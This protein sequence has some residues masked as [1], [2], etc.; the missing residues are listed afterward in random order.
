MKDQP[1]PVDGLIES[2]LPPT[3]VELERL[4]GPSFRENSRRTTHWSPATLAERL[5][6]MTIAIHQRPG[7]P[8][9]LLR[10]ASGASLKRH[11]AETG[12]GYYSLR[13]ALPA[14]AVSLL[15]S[16]KLGELKFVHLKALD[17]A[18]DSRSFKTPGHQSA[19]FPILETEEDREV[20]ERGPY[21]Y[22][23]ACAVTSA[24][25]AIPCAFE[26]VPSAHW[27]P[28]TW[29]ARAELL[30]P[31]LRRDDEDS[32]AYLR[33]VVDDYRHQLAALA[34]RPESFP[35]PQT[36]ADLTASVYTG[37]RLGE[38]AAGA[39]GYLTQVASAGGWLVA[40]PNQLGGLAQSSLGHSL[41][42]LL[43]IKDF[44]SMTI[45]DLCTRGAGAGGLEDVAWRFESEG[46]SFTGP[47]LHQLL[48]TQPGE[49]PWRNVTDFAPSE[50]GVRWFIARGAAHYKSTPVPAALLALRDTKGR[51]LGYSV[52]VCLDP[53]DRTG[54]LRE[55]L[56]IAHADT[57]RLHG[58]AGPIQRVKEEIEDV[59]ALNVQAQTAAPREVIVAMALIVVAARL[60][61]E[62][63]GER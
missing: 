9:Q 12:L 51:R 38:E 2:L 1:D 5:S 24:G 33:R 15:A 53:L 19:R 55:A 42:G 63:L 40:P 29:K 47:E 21:V 17:S 34:G 39:P 43:A 36:L 56:C 10:I 31:Q 48:M 26:V 4:L 57:F 14:F 35:L 50:E 3:V 49:A 8:L 41:E 58:A 62:A 13:H 11:Q 46:V 28:A 30:A 20:D 61:A 52:R 59:G 37:M 18:P 60:A 7:A 25:V 27:L 54:R 6:R 44:G 32:A 16:G 23:V 22:F 45:A